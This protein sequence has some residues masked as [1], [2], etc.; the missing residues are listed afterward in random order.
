[1][2]TCHSLT[3]TRELY[4]STD[5]FLHSLYD[6]RKK[7]KLLNEQVIQVDF[8]HLPSAEMKELQELPNI[9]IF[10]QMDHSVLSDFLCRFVRAYIFKGLDEVEA[11]KPGERYR[12][13]SSKQPRL[14][15]SCRTQDSAVSANFYGFQ[16]PNH[17]CI[18]YKHTLTHTYSPHVVRV[19]ENKTE[20]RLE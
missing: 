20:T 1:M 15:S 10:L 4:Y 16:T 14:L 19:T 5:A 18:Q 6:P 13:T 2:E 12:T 3:I 11:S 7:A 8:H 17:T 9:L